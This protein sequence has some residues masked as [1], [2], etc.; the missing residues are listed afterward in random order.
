VGD[1]NL[2]IDIF[3]NSLLEKNVN[4]IIPRKIELVY[5]SSIKDDIDVVIKSCDFN[6]LRGVAVKLGFKMYRDSPIFHVYLYGAGPHYHF[7]NHDKN[8]HI[9]VTEKWQHKSTNYDTCGSVVIKKWLPVHE[10]LQIKMWESVESSSIVAWGRVA[11][12]EIELTHIMCHVL[13]DKDRVSSFYREKISQLIGCV[14]IIILLRY[15]N[16]IFYK[17]SKKYVDL[18][19]SRRFDDI[20]T[21]YLSFGEY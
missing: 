17:F 1:R 9:D 8:I 14:D 12:S 7:I 4:F 2:T 21:E 16:L 13:L 10:E 19:K 15:L 18:C 20:H 6:K 3:F 5:E 11:S